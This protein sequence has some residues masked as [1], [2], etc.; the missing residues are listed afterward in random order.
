MAPVEIFTKGKD[1]KFNDDV[2]LSDNHT[3]VVC[4]GATDTYKRELG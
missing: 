1:K 3:W 4:D 2:A